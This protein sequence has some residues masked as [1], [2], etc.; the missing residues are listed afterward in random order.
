[1]DISPSYEVISEALSNLSSFR[2]V[3]VGERK[4]GKSTFCRY[5]LNSLLSSD[6]KGKVDSSID[7]ADFDCGQTEF[8]PPQ[9]ISVATFS[10]PKDFLL[11]PPFT[12]QHTQPSECRYLGF[13]SPTSN[14][15]AYIEACR[16]LLSA[17]MH[18]HDH[19]MIVN[20]MGWL[21][22]LGLELLTELI[23]SVK[24][25]HLVFFQ[26]G[27]RDGPFDRF[28]QQYTRI[29]EE[30]DEDSF[31]IA[32]LDPKSILEP[33][34]SALSPLAFRFRPA[35][36]RDLAMQAYFKGSERVA[37]PLKAIRIL[38]TWKTMVRLCIDSLLISLSLLKIP[39]LPAEWSPLL[40]EVPKISP[41]S[42]SSAASVWGS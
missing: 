19:R 6:S 13:T 20:T 11:G 14:P 41:N 35:E 36:Q 30:E 26:D 31:D 23:K 3:I 42:L 22:G 32:Y 7:F 12:H 5:L 2:V 17:K 1:M 24:P 27:P 15:M 18:K 29:R 25:T 40:K 16:S 34:S 37:V 39:F 33:A 38:Y 21:T 8:T 4:V 28:V 9:T 10:G